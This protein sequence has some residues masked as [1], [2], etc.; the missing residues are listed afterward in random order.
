MKHINVGQLVVEHKCHEGLDDEFDSY[1]LDEDK[2]IDILEP[3]MSE[4]G[5]VVDFHTCEIF[6]ERWFSLVLVLRTETSELY[7]RLTARQYS[8]KKLDE[9]ME[10]EIM[11]VVKE[12]AFESYN[13][14]IVHE[15]Q[16][17]TIDDQESNVDRVVSW[18][19]QWVIDNQ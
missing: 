13:E 10:A 8:K 18:L 19:N 6:P 11:E 1:V 12:A 2:I 14:N 5:N 9:N 16:S 15:L 7:D 17:N 4:G 3:I